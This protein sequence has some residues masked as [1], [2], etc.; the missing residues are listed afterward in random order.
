MTGQQ[1]A[2]ITVGTPVAGTSA[3]AT[4]VT[5]HRQQSRASLMLNDGDGPLLSR[6]VKG[7]RS[8]MSGLAPH[9]LYQR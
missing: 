4:S 8:K 3:I 6:L 7:L 5:R 1:R 2:A 9:C